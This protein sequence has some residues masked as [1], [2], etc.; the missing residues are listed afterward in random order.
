MRPWAILYKKYDEMRTKRFIRLRKELGIDTIIA[1][2]NAIKDLY[3]PAAVTHQKVFPKYK[4]INKG[5]TVV[6]VGT[7]PTLD[8]YTPIEGAVHIGVNRAFLREDIPLDYLIRCDRM[9]DEIEKQ[10]SEY[11]GNNCKKLYGYMYRS[12][13][14]IPEYIKDKEDVE[15]FYCLSYDYQKYGYDLD[16]DRFFFFPPDISVSPFK[17]YGTTMFIVFQF[18]LWTHPEKIYLVGCDCTTGHCALAEDNSIFSDYSYLI[19]PWK[20][21]KEFAEDF[22]PDIEITSINPVGLKGIFHD[23]YTESY[24]EFLNKK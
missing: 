12:R 16:K 7:A 21:A 14:C 19:N 23:E 4:G 11:R 13:A 24:K 15:S 8:Y 3:I 17:S 18:A 22:Y 6:L 9:E 1:H 10:I 2:E 5:K 20:K